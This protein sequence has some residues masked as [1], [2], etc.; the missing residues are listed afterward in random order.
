MNYERTLP[1]ELTTMVNWSVTLL[2]E[3]IKDQAGTKTFS[4]VEG[5][6]QKTKQTQEGSP[7]QVRAMIESMVLELEKRPSKI[8]HEVCHAFGMMLELI[9]AC[10]AAYRSYRLKSYPFPDLSK[11]SVE[12]ITYVLTAH[13]TEAKTIE[14]IESFE[15]IQ[16]VL[17]ES[18]IEG[19]AQ[20]EQK[21]KFWLTMA[22]Q[23]PMA[24]HKK[25]AVKDEAEAIC[26]LALRPNV[27]DRWV[28][29]HQSGV[30]LYLRTWVGG[31][32]D[33]HPGVD[34]L[35]MKASLNTS[36]RHL[37]HFMQGRCDKSLNALSQIPRDYV[38]LSLISN[39][40]SLKTSLQKLKRIE[41]GDGARC[42]KLAAKVARANQVYKQELGIPCY[43]L[44][45]MQSLL[46]ITPALVIPLELR[47]DSEVVAQAVRTPKK[48]AIG[49]MLASLQKISGP[50][51]TDWYAKGFILSM[52]ESTEDLLN[53]VELVKRTIPRQDIPVVPLFE[54]EKAL[55]LGPEIIRE[56][57][58]KMGMKK[59][60]K[61]RWE[62]SLEIMVGY[63]DSSKENGSLRSRQLIESALF[64]MEQAIEECGFKPRFFH[65]S[66]GS[67]ARGGGS[68]EDQTSWWPKTARSR[69]KATIQG[70]MIAR[71]FS[72][73]EVFTRQAAKIMDQSNVNPEH[74]PQKYQS[75]IESLAIKTRDHY[76][77]MVSDSDFMNVVAN[78]TPY[79]YLQL[80]K[81]GSRPSKRK[82]EFSLASLRAI[83]WILCW[84][85]TRV[86]FPS[87]WG[88]G[89]AWKS[90]STEEKNKLKEAYE[91]SP[92]F[93]SYIHVMGFTLSKVSLGVWGAYLSHSDIDEE[94]Q[95]SVHELVSVEY[96]MAL[97]CIHEISASKELLW[98]KPWL[99]VSISLRNPLIHPLNALQLVALKYKDNTLL[100]ETVT[101]IASGMMTT[102]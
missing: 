39:I 94:V 82:A 60:V 7:E 41:S 72:S 68:I 87:W 46:E 40:K 64:K 96:Q 11:S 55:L 50:S 63:S 33:G 65:G 100:R 47:E 19:R 54:N 38:A 52:T 101:G 16:S 2:G 81:I 23:W 15:K 34:E 14:L 98:Y 3:V 36:R 32:K 61:S 13:P 51:P 5:L 57:S 77:M 8:Q 44:T 59:L 42:E 24:K 58:K 37:I 70:E 21:L 71:S 48:F 92:L 83:P 99:G 9:N 6:R 22:W 84:T 76:R 69:F 27:V 89:S 53:G 26:T 78:S 90:C 45:Q 35:A 75:A 97:Q 66:G 49:R 88:L 86:L 102:G 67:V 62:N 43:Y 1:K 56:F 74:V 91:N 93:R 30:P 4:I 79:N 85:Q 31:D 95:N 29:L 20:V 12:R 25:P 18:L 28:Q 10:E 73:P 17:V 80:L